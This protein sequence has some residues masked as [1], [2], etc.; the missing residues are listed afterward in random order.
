MAL[1]YQ[2]QNAC[3]YYIIRSYKFYIG[4]IN[5]YLF[6]Q[7]PSDDGNASD[8]SW[9]LTIVW[10]HE[11]QTW[12]FS[13]LSACLVGLSGIFPLVI[14]PIDAGKSLRTG[15]IVLIFLDLLVFLW[16]CFVCMCCL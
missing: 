8:V 13:I 14:I 2:V 15:G 11:T 16:P 4:L 10:G 9:M 7:S 5:V 6:F 1:F 3:G 12:L